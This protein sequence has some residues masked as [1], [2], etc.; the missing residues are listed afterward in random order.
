[1]RIAISLGMNRET[2]D[3]KVDTREYQHRRRL[4]WTLY[5]IDRKISIMAGGPVSIRDDEIDISTPGKDDLDYDNA[6]LNLHIKLA[7]L[8][9][10]IIS[11]M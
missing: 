6:A 7:A 8:E 4:W 2:P 3:E 9:G 10:R 5:I 1:M 11:G